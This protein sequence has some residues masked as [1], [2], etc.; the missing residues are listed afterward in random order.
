MATQLH[1]L[2]G[3]GVSIEAAIAARSLAAAVVS[4]AVRDLAGSDGDAA[5]RWLRGPNALQWLDA[6]DADQAALLEA[7]AG[8]RSGPC[9]NLTKHDI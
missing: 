2:A 5:L 6:I 8:R 1:V 3:P 9:Q 4:R 7:I